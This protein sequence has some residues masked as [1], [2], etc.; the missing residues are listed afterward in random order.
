MNKLYLSLN[1]AGL[2]FKGHTD[3]GEVDFIPP[4]ND[5]ISGCKNI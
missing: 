5:T 2:M 1:K 3:Q 4:E